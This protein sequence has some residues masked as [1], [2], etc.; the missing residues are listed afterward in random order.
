LE[1]PTWKVL[2]AALKKHRINNDDWQSY[3]MFISYGPQGMCLFTP[4][5]KCN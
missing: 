5:L 1:D 2:P 3:A 4:N